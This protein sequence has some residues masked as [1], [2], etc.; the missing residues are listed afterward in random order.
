V[1]PNHSLE[2]T[3]YASSEQ[4]KAATLRAQPLTVAAAVQTASPPLVS[5]PTLQTADASGAPY[6]GILQARPWCPVN[7]ILAFNLGS[8]V[9]VVSGINVFSPGP[10]TLSEADR[11]EP[12][13]RHDHGV[14][15][16]LP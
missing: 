15:R 5:N 4:T 9:V 11:L 6:A 8:S 14:Y 2:L 10:A 7:A 13:H 3:R 16:R 12:Q 1:S